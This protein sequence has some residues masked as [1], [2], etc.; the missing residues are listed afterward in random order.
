MPRFRRRHQIVGILGDDP[1]QQFTA[2][3]VARDDHATFAIDTQQSGS[4]I[5]TKARS[6]SPFIRTM[7]FETRSR[8]KRPN[9]RLEVHAG[10][11]LTCMR[12]G[13]GFVDEMP[14][15]QHREVGDERSHDVKMART[16][17]MPSLAFG[18]CHPRNI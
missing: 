3:G 18:I 6:A 15:R 10:F 9:L 8:E 17:H 14:E 13:R 4:T 2:F 11:A 1:L 16:F 7:T 5:K 12:R